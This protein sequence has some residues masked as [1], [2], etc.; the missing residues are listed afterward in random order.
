MSYKNTFIQIAEDSNVTSANIPFPRNEKPTIASIE[1]DL[2]KSNPYQYTQDDVQFKTYLIKNE[3]D[4]N[5]EG[6]EITKTIFLKTKG[7]L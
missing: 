4:L 2:I 1:Y 5:S 7:L 6:N 3:L